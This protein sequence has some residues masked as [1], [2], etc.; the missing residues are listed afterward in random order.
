MIQRISVLTRY[1]IQSLLF[2]LT[3]LFYL[4]LML[5]FWFVLFNPQQQTPDVAYYQ[6]LIGAFG[7][8]LV[9]LVTLSMAARANDAQHYPFVVRLRA[10]WSL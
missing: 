6:L 5:A 8:G 9:F 1:F 7:A 4:L 3:G 2:S 10:G